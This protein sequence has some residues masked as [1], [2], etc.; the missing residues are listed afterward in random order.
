MEQAFIC[1]FL[2]FSADTYAVSQEVIQNICLGRIHK[3]LPKQRTID[4][5][6]IH[7]HK[8]LKQI[9]EVYSISK[10]V[11]QISTGANMEELFRCQITS[12]LQAYPLKCTDTHS[13]FLG[14]QQQENCFPTQEQHFSAVRSGL[15][16]TGQEAP[17]YLVSLRRSCLWSTSNTIRSTTL[18]EM[19]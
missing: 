8:S 5:K 3:N 11:F 13:L 12:R 15:F 1:L 7:R 16:S 10:Y 4:Y 2:T 17:R 14:E 18:F 9:D 6:Y 19:G